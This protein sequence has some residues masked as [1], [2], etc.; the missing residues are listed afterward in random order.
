[1][2][3]AA[4]LFRPRSDDADLSGGNWL[5]NG[6]VSL[7][8]VQDDRYWRIARS[9]SAS[10]ADTQI[11]VTLDR[12]RSLRGAALILPNAT[13]AATFRISAHGEPDFDSAIF[14][15]D[16]ISGGESDLTWKDD[17][18]APIL[19]TVFP[20]DVSARYWLVEID[21]NTN[22]LGYIDVA[23]LFLAEA[24]SP[25]FNYTFSGNSLT[26][27]NN[28]L[29]SSTLSGGQRFWRRVSPREWVC[30]F[31][32]LP[33]A[34]VFGDVYEF[35]RYVG[36]DR[37][38]FIVSDPADMNHA[39]QRRFFATISQL[40]PI[41]QSVFERG[42]FGFGVS[43]I[44]ALSTGGSISVVVPTNRVRQRNHVPAIV[45]AAEI[46]V[47]TDGVVQRDF[48]PSVTIGTLLVLPT[49]AQVQRDRAP[50]VV[51][52]ASVP[53]PLDV[54]AQSDHAPEVVADSSILIPLD[55]QIQHDHAPTVVS[56]AAVRLP[57][58]TQVQEDH[59]PLIEADG[60]I[61]LPVDA[62]VQADH[63][64]KV[65]TAAVVDVPVSVSVQ[66]DFAPLV[67]GAVLITPPA[68]AARQHDHAPAIVTGVE[69][70]VGLDAQIQVD[71]APSV[72]T[73]SV[74]AAPGDSARQTDHAP[75]VSTGAIVR[76]P[77]DR[78]VHTEFAPAVGGGA[79]VPVPVDT[80]RQRDHAPAELAA[81]DD[82]FDAG[83]A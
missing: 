52:G 33:E 21:D 80:M 16:M 28:T 38:V 8:N 66:R 35:L 36:Y 59:A 24:L 69:I 34:E 11:R 55:A 18:R 76:P 58:D 67:G 5:S 19:S 23:R 70:V 79:N 51:S 40:N 47:S 57:P 77:A 27:R 26:F 43:E 63:A 42:D 31:Q 41:V 12:V 50:V 7:A 44:V 46:I 29:S 6:D 4:F 14:S 49:D 17:E 61:R 82:G 13:T 54:Q 45:T 1:M 15:T 48:A 53:V 39:Q 2:G 65:S 37:E 60:T 22:A 62:Q 32:Y 71:H 72:A 25:S 3:S 20:G 81:F 75:V 73:G 78:Q 64:P 83:F 9:A 74:V 10:P 56:G 68:D 30:S